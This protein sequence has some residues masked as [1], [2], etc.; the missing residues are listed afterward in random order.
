MIHE[1][2]EVA[3]LIEQSAGPAAPAQGIDGA[4]RHEGEIVILGTD[5]L[6]ES[7]RIIGHATNVCIQLIN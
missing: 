2:Q 6:K 3:S 7:T 4:A 5:C 1:E